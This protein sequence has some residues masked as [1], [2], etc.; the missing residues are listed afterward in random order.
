MAVI[1]GTE[2]AMDRM[3][4][5]KG[6]KGGLIINTASLAGIGIGLSR[7]SASYFIAKHGVVTLTRT[8]G[9]GFI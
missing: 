6:G 5:S 4:Q 9:V 8:L 7:E 1:S 2:L 3:D